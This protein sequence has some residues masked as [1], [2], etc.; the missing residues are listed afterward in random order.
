MPEE[1]D[2]DE[3]LA[4]LFMSRARALRRRWSGSV[5]PWDLSPHQARALRVVASHE[6]ARRGEVASHLRIAPRSATEVLD[7]LEARDLVRR[8]A[9]PD[10]RR[11]VRVA[12]TPQGRSVL[13]EVSR[14]RDGE[15]AAY[16]ASLSPREQTQLA[17]LLRRLDP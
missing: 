14:A 8:E 13:A 2:R 16:L 1:T 11:A 5:A 7:G 17:R 15:S 6:P 3:P 12:L 9:D 10:D 4:D